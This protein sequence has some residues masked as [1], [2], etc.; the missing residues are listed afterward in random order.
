MSGVPLG[1]EEAVLSKEKGV[2]ASDVGLPDVVNAA[3]DEDITSEIGQKS[4]ERQ[5]E[6]EEDGSS[7]LTE[8]SDDDGMLE[9]HD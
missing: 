8:Q 5:D 9:V 7:E 6:V 3:D 4:E 1:G 2:V